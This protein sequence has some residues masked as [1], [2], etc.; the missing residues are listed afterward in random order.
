MT[1]DDRDR[2]AALRDALA[3]ADA[4]RALLAAHGAAAAAPAAHPEDE[5]LLARILATDPAGSGGAGRGARPAV[6]PPA[7]PAP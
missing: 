2:D 1:D 3:E 7:D 5:D 4:L 6:V